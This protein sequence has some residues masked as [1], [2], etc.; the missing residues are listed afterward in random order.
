MEKGKKAIASFCLCEKHP[1]AT[2]FCVSQ[3]GSTKA[4]MLSQPILVELYS[5][6]KKDDISTLSLRYAVFLQFFVF[7]TGTYF[8][9]VL[10]TLR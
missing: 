5:C 9:A 1:K 7:F 2:V 3:L 10:K 6:G 8:V 4:S